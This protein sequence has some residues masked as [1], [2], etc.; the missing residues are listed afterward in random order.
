[1]TSILTQLPTSCNCGRNNT[2]IM[3]FHIPNRSKAGMRASHVTLYTWS[4]WDLDNV[5]R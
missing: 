3:R 2:V 4:H 5:S 1:M